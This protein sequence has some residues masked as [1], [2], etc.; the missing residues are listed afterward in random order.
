MTEQE[1]RYANI[2]EWKLETV[3]SHLALYFGLSEADIL[4]PKK[5]REIEV[6]NHAIYICRYMLKM[7]I[8][9]IAKRLAVKIS[10]VKQALFTNN[11][12]AEDLMALFA[13]TRKL[14]VEVK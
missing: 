12:D 10:D 3:V 14:R 8:A 4:A 7:S 13:G 5:F 9:A 2:K 11:E 6:R 1:D